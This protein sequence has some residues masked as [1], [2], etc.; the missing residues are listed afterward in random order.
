MKQKLIIR[1]LIGAPL[2]LTL[3]TLIAI[4][5]SLFIGDGNYY[6]VV[7]QLEQDLGNP[8]N[9]VILQSVCS[10]LYG[11]AWAG[12]SIIWSLDWGLLRQTV[13]HLAVCSIATFPVAYFMYWMEHTLFGI[14]SYFGIFLVIYL[15]IWISQYQVMKHK[16]QQM[17]QKLQLSTTKDLQ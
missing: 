11:A 12:A 5:I 4:V 8:L 14:L 9:A 3:S 10:L 2:G 15:I 13:T 6:P 1:C 7:P 17:N 16:I